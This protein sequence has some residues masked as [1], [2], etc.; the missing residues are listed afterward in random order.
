MKKPIFIFNVVIAIAVIVLYILYF[1]LQSKK[2][3]IS[4]DHVTS[5]QNTIKTS[6]SGNNL[7]IAYVNTDSVLAGYHLYNKLKNTLESEQS[8]AERGY[9]KKMKEFEKKYKSYSVMVQRGLITEEKATQELELMQNDVEI[10]RKSVTEKLFKKNEELVEQVYNSI[11][12]FVSLHNDSAGY[13]YIFS[14]NGAI[15]IGPD[16][17]DISKDILQSLNEAHNNK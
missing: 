4:Q 2:V 11:I 16:N 12:E 9:E 14:K 3:T 15:L 7:S 8:A 17:F 5:H 13:T 6:P 1:S 10:Y